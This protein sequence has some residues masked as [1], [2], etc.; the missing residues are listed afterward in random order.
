L[1]TTMESQTPSSKCLNS[2]LGR[3]Q[4]PGDIVRSKVALTRTLKT[5]KR[6]KR[7]KQLP[8][9]VTVDS[10]S[11]LSTSS[12]RSS[13]TE[14]KENW[15]SYYLRPNKTLCSR[16]SQEWE[17]NWRIWS[18][19][20]RWTDASLAESRSLEASW[21]L[22]SKS[23]QMRKTSLSIWALSSKVV[24]EVADFQENCLHQEK[25]LPRTNLGESLEYPSRLVLVALVSLLLQSNRVSVY[26]LLQRWMS[27]T[28]ICHPWVLIHLLRAV[29]KTNLA[30]VNQRHLRSK[31]KSMT[32][33]QLLRLRKLPKEAFN[34]WLRSLQAQ[35]RSQ[36]Y[37][38]YRRL[39]SSRERGLILLR[40][41]KD[42]F[43]KRTN[44]QR[45][46]HSVL[47]PIRD[48]RSVPVSMIEIN[49]LTKMRSR[50]W[51][52]P[53]QLGGLRIASMPLKK[54]NIWIRPS[55]SLENKYTNLNQWDS[56][57]I[58]MVT[59]LILE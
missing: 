42:L 50:K 27:I 31:S 6:S 11:S 25:P 30:S 15:K 16:K 54:L 22:S 19:K 40:S 57:L 35:L 14:E 9:V 56:E 44:S 2:A 39:K 12:W 51:Q 41:H 13:L 28:T 45:L 48:L 53:T 59:E 21:P 18:F 26:R 4:T 17:T 52:N 20:T 55:F 58:A 7:S 1:Q 5:S 10:L 8:S 46:S 43:W 23:L 49:L 34:W 47:P 24:A 32:S 33:L 38:L 29:S 36:S 37:P 3:D